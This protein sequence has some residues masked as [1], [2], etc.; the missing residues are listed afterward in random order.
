LL[1]TKKGLTNFAKDCILV[2]LKE[3]ISSKKP[4]EDWKLYTNG[5]EQAIKLNS[6]S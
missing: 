6:C 2:A 3:K 1:K 4:E 5:N